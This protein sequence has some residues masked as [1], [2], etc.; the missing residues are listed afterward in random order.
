M[1]SHR[2]V[3]VERR[4]ALH[5]EPGQ[6]HRAHDR[7]AKGV[8]RVL[9]G[10][11]HRH[12]LAIGRLKAALHHHSVR[13]DVEAPLPEIAHF[14]LRFADD[15]LDNRALHPLRLAAQAVELRRQPLPEVEVGGP[16]KRG[17]PVGDERLEP[18]E[19]RLPARLDALEHPRAG[20]LVD[21][22]QHRL[23]RLPAGRAVL[24][25]V[26][27]QLVQPVVGRDHFVVL[28]EQLLQQG[29]LIRIEVGLLNRI[30]DPVVQIEASQPQLLA[31]VLVH[32]LDR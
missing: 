10:L 18:G 17:L 32:Q 21:A 20:D 11:V 24:G 9:E 6:P 8:L 16:S 31:P 30:G 26:L 4:Q 5:V 2:L 13:D 14:V 12:P 28:A 22:H 23:A 3:D 29:L 1:R 7:D 27:G 19:S 15:D 25:E